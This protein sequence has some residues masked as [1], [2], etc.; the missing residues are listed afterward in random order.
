MLDD[1][2]VYLA[3][4]GEPATYTPG[5]GEPAAITV[6]YDEEYG[7]G[8]PYVAVVDMQGPVAQTKTENVP[9]IDAAAKFTIRGVEYSVTSIQPDGTGWVLIQLSRGL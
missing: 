6:I 3:D 5:A 9:G 1:L 7:A 8:S 2:D 4:F